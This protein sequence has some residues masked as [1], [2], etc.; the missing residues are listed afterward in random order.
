ME[1][2]GH[3]LELVV[4]KSVDGMS[5]S[6]LW[7]VDGH[8]TYGYFPQSPRYL[9]LYL[10]HLLVFYGILDRLVK[11]DIDFGMSYV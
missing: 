7:F 6:V 3:G 2:Q 9:S 8:L 10:F 4:P 1:N 5:N 11:C